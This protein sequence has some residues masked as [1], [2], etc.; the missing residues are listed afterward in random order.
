MQQE[1]SR[2]L[3]C[4]DALAFWSLHSISSVLG[5]IPKHVEDRHNVA[6]TGEDRTPLLTR[7]FQ[8]D[9]GSLPLL[10]WASLH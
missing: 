6:I 7:V 3:T 4:S 2:V 1:N 10:L 8:V 9:T 5:V